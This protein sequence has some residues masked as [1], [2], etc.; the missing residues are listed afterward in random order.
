MD[1]QVGLR[2]DIIAPM[3]ATMGDVYGK[4]GYFHIESLLNPGWAP[5]PRKEVEDYAE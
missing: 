2:E 3:G 5:W 1:C 4:V